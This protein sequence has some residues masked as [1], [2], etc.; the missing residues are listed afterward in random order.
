MEGP[1]LSQG[2]WRYRHPYYPRDHHSRVL[3][4]VPRVLGVVPRV[5]GVVGRG[6]PQGRDGG[7]G[8]GVLP[9]ADVEALES[10]S[11]GRGG[12]QGRVGRGEGSVFGV[13]PPT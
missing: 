11:V 6:I 4:V 10:R 2:S 12:W 3:G 1:P 7:D 5:L 9:G 13:L 8:D